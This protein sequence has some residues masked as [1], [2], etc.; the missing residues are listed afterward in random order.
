MIPRE[1]A[2]EWG[3]AV[4]GSPSHLAHQAVPA[5]VEALREAMELHARIR[6]SGA[7][8]GGHI[9]A[10]QRALLRAYKGEPT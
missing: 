1:Q 6:A 5:L 10:D 2:E 4:A 3:A 9:S 8:L 7:M